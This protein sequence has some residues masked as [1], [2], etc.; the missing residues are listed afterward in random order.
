MVFEE[1]GVV[2]ECLEEEPGLGGD[3]LEVVGVV[4]ECLEDVG[5]VYLEEEDGGESLSKRRLRG[6]VRVCCAGSRS[7]ACD[8]CERL[9][10]CDRPGCRANGVV[11]TSLC[12]VAKGLVA[13][14]G[15]KVN[16][17]LRLPRAWMAISSGEG[18]GVSSASDKFTVQ[19]T[20][21]VMSVGCV[22]MC[23]TLSPSS[24]STKSPGR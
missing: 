9:E 15:E 12:R 24:S 11:E 13:R 20:L 5:V 3:C 10:R 7:R 2:G 18:L 16:G 21:S 8:A 19:L 22:G 1:T 4:G 6:E 17:T 23:A 14:S